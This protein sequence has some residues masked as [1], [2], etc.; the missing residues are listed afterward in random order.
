MHSSAGTGGAAAMPA[1]PSGVMGAG[2]APAAGTGGAGQVSNPVATG[3]TGSMPQPDAG[4][5]ML[6]AGASDASK[7]S[8]A[9]RDLDATRDAGSD[10]GPAAI[11]Q[12]HEIRGVNWADANDNFVDGVLQLS[13]LD[14]NTDT[15]DTVHAKA[16]QVAAEFRDKLGANTIRIPINEP[17]VASPFWDAYKAVI[18]ATTELGMN[19]IIAYWAHHNGKPDDETA[20][21]SMW[22]KVVAAYPDNNR[23]L[24]DIHNEPSG[25]GASWNDEAA[26]WLGYFP[27]VPRGRVIVAGTGVDD[28]VVPVGSDSRF[29]GCMLQL[30]FYGYWHEDWTTQ[31]QW[32]DDLGKRLG[33]Y[34]SRTIIGEWGAAMSTNLDYGTSTPDGNNAISYITACADFMRDNGMGNVYWPGLRDGDSYSMMKRDMGTGSITLS[35]VNASGRDRLRWSWGL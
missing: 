27:D 14:R 18:D 19:V 33:A 3:G 20:F 32:T 22:Q 25:F 8:D 29:D 15:Y 26:Q 35:V 23:V 10:A 17:T 1:F 2:G 34:A 21:K 30:H 13:G 6:D 24:F 31:K 9:S 12:A 7:P 28:N 16:A 4:H 5:A 11:P